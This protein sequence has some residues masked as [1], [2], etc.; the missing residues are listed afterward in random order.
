[1][2][3]EAQCVHSLT[4]SKSNAIL[5]CG[6]ASSKEMKEMENAPAQAL[7]CIQLLRQELDVELFE[8]T[9]HLLT[10]YSLSRLVSLGQDLPL[11]A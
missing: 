3:F 2:C 11:T 4:E 10:S 5:L 9:M 7:S 6:M 8:Q 1:V